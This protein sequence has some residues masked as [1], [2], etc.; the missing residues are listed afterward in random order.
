MAILYFL[1]GISIL[2]YEYQKD[3][4]FVASLAKAVILWQMYLLMAT[5][6]FSVFGLLNHLS[7]TIFHL[8][9]ITIYTNL[10]VR[11]KSNPLSNIKEQLMTYKSQFT[12]SDQVILVLMCILGGVLLFGAIFTVPYNY[13]SMTYHLARIGHWVD[14]QSVNHYSTNIDRQIYS[15]VLS[16]Y[17]M[18]HLFLLAGNDY[19]LNL[20]QYASLWITM[21]FL[22][23]NTR[24]LGGNRT[25]GLLV[26][27]LFMTMP[28]TISQSITTQNDL[29]AAMFFALF[30]YLLLY[31]IKLPS[32][33]INK[34]VV[35]NLFLAGAAVGL[36]FLA[37]TSICAS[38]VFFIPWLLIVRLRHKDHLLN[39]IK[40]ALIAGVTMVAFISETLIRNFLSAGKL[41]P[42]TASSNI[43]VSTKNV[44][45]IL[46]N[47]LKNFSLLITQH[48]IEPL[49]GVIYRFTI[50]MGRILQVQVNHEAISY[51]EFD[52]IRHMNMGADMYSHDKAPSAVVAYLAVVSMIVLVGL[53]IVQ[54]NKKDVHYD[55]LGYGISS[56]LSLGFIMA[57]LRWQP[58]GTRLLYPALSMMTILIGLCFCQQNSKRDR[59]EKENKKRPIQQ[60]LLLGVALISLVFAIA[61]IGYNLSPAM[62]YVKGGLK[63][64]TKYYFT[65]NQR[66]TEYEQLINEVEKLA[67]DQVGVVIS[68]DGYDYPLWLLFRQELPKVR[69]DHVLID[70]EPAS[71]PASKPASEPASKS[72]KDAPSCILVIE[73]G[74]NQVGDVLQV[75]ETNYICTFVCD[76][77]NKDAIYI[78]Q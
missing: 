65:Y 19:F 5:N 47:I 31:F 16:E 46:V 8:G 12:F 66:R 68:G 60:A 7:V 76:T 1:S 11:K 54:K 40:A 24:I 33:E 49:N 2:L 59:V 15:P 67:V 4:K 21:V 48:I 34:E 28:L 64:R 10:L 13:D 17:N 50:E 36:S 58:W 73:R 63:D 45:Y 62:S 43:A 37:K 20:V 74:D 69:L 22:Y 6:L 26:A 71:K 77:A 75:E 41:M 27:F 14:Y 55:A 53:F 25:V 52:F 51:H 38:M 29:F 18:L 44:S 39:L 3:N 23:K 42:E 9:M 61:S 57:L 56:W 32:L 78:L 70:S 30:I 72:N 35:I